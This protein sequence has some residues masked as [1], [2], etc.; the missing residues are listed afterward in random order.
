MPYFYKSPS[1][2]DLEKQ[3][4]VFKCQSPTPHQGCRWDLN[5]IM[6]FLIFYCSRKSS[7][8]VFLFLITSIIFFN[9]F[10]HPLLPFLCFF[11]I[12]FCT[13]H[14]V[15]LSFATIVLHLSLPVSL[16]LFVFFLPC[17]LSHYADVL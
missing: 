11:K 2:H 15:L 14:S 4:V 10:L 12:V 1:L 7:S 8:Y 6:T 3:S 16:C 17:F 13:C 5:K 9:F